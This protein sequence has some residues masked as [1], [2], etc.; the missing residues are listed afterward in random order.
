MAGLDFSPLRVTAWVLIALGGV[1]LLSLLWRLLQ[2]I[3][4]RF[5]P[6]NVW[7]RYAQE[8]SPYRYRSSGLW[9]CLGT[10]AILFL[11]LLLGGA[12]AGLLWVQQGLQDY[13]P[14]P[15]GEVVAQVRCRPAEV[16][17]GEAMSCTLSL[18]DPVYSD[19]LSLGGLRW[20]LQGELIA[21]KEPLEEFGLSSGYRLLRLEAYDPRGQLV[22]SVALPGSDGGLGQILPWLGRLEFLVRA[23]QQVLS[24][25]AAGNQFYE[26]T[27][28]R[29]GFSLREWGP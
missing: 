16:A 26:L 1:L 23:R 3:R 9:G 5:L 8:S 7:E 4:S 25:E 14:L 11:G 19:T 22:D 12:G 20:G 21:W 2:G 24:G 29:Q 10:L 6:V 28:S 15:E 13:A 18:M 27:V 17:S